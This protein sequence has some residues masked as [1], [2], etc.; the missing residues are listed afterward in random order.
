LPDPKIRN[1][2]VLAG[3]EIRVLLFEQ[4]LNNFFG[5]SLNLQTRYDDCYEDRL[6]FDTHRIK[7]EESILVK[8]PETEWRNKDKKIC[9]IFEF[10]NFFKLPGHSLENTA[11]TNGYACLNLSELSKLEDFELAIEGGSPMKEKMLKIKEEDIRKGRKGIIANVSSW[12]EGK[13][14]PKLFGRIKPIF[15]Q[16]ANNTKQVEDLDLLPEVG[17]YHTPSLDLLAT[18]R[19]NLGR[20]AFSFMQAVNGG[21]NTELNSELYVIAL[22]HLLNLPLLRSAVSAFWSSYLE[23]VYPSQP[24]E[25]KMQLCKLLFKRLYFVMTSTTFGFNKSHPSNMCYGTTLLE[26]RKDILKAEFFHF[27]DEVSQ[28]CKMTRPSKLK[29]WDSSTTVSSTELGHDAFN[30]EELLENDN[31]GI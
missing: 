25:L 15:R 29:Y 12:F 14:T 30:I 16:P 19:Q 9:V 6:Y 21:I 13:V 22:S 2:A 5:N 8:I 1:N 20:D 26:T 11:V 17:V 18:M 27:W 4:N 3:R 31:F 28:I 24:Y 7:G 23:S 10:V